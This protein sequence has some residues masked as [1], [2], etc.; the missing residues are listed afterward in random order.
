M[1]LSFL[2][3][4]PRTPALDS[5][6]L[7]VTRMTGSIG[8]LWLIVAALL[9]AFKRTRKAGVAVLISYLGVLLFGQLILKHLVS[10]PRPCQVDPTF[11]L[12]LERPSGSSFPSTHSAWSFAAATAIFMFHRKGGAV[13]FVAAALIAFSRLYLFVH[14][15]TDVLFGVALG[16]ALGVAASRLSTPLMQKPQRGAQDPAAGN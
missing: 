11:A 7:A 6:F 12:L 5:F 13:A 8:Q 2:Y 16:M 14:F 10:R 15:P 9:L 1:E 4:I 3:A